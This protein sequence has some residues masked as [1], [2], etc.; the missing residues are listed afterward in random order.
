MK[1]TK[2]TIHVVESDDKPRATKLKLTLDT[3]ASVKVVLKRTKKLHGKVVKA[4][5][6]KALKKGA[7]TIKLT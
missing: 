4:T 2:K 1:L 5:L 6:T 3:D 7:A